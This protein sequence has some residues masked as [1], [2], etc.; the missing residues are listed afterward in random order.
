[1]KKFLKGVFLLYGIYAAIVISYFLLIADSSNLPNGYQGSAADPTTF[2]NDRQLELTYEYSKIRHIIF[3]LL[4]PFD[5]VF[6]LTIL[7]VGF[8]VRFR[9]WSESVTK[10]SLFQ[11]G[12]YVFWLSVFTFII[13]FPIDYISY[14][15]SKSYG[16]TTST[17][18][19]W[20]KDQFIDF[21]LDYL[22]MVVLAIVVYA[23]IK[24]YNKRWWIYAWVISVPFT[25]FLMFVQPVIIDPLY[26]DFYPLKDKELEEKILN[27]ASKADIPAE[28]VYEVNMS[29]K[30][31][32]LNAYVTGIGS[33]SRIVLWDTTL[34]K[35]NDSE[36]LFVMAHEMAHYVKKHIYMGM[37]AYLLISFIGLFIASKILEWAVK[38]F[39]QRLLIKGIN[40]IASLPLLLL[41]IS[42]LTFIQSPIS[43][44]F[45]RY[46]EH[47]ADEYAIEMTNDKTA[48]ISG[49]QKLTI[50]G[51]SEVNPPAI[52]KWLRYGHPTMLERLNFLENYDVKQTN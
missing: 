20:M 30:T 26:N 49:F 27:L 9:N 31:N 10:I 51:L 32:A 46:L 3:F 17:F 28:H 18:V 40:D 24:K 15:L 44:A 12:I 35:L 4:T 19:I 47:S 29:E 37:A 39:G 22:F 5:W 11:K 16:I 33:N 6:F 21:W 23:L 8:S 34:N 48:A 42:M 1:M 7:A 45:S 38:R 13:M 43:N 36:V 50:A 2:M 14:Q 25:V 52:V 41:I